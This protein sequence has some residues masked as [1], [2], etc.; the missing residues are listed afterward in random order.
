MPNCM[1]SLLSSGG[2]NPSFSSISRFLLLYPTPSAS[3]YLLAVTAHCCR[4]CN[5]F[6]SPCSKNGYAI[7]RSIFLL[8]HP[9]LLTRS[10]T[11]VVARNVG[12]LALLL[13]SEQ[14]QVVHGFHVEVFAEHN[15]LTRRIPLD[16][17]R[18]QRNGFA[19]NFGWQSRLQFHRRKW[20]EFEWISWLLLGDCRHQRQR[21]LLLFFAVIGSVHEQR[22]T[23]NQKCCFFH[24]LS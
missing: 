24:Y 23:T 21:L 14:R 6:S 9:P 12:V 22:D 17:A 3:A 4:T 19:D 7:T 20:H 5:H 15:H 10:S 2:F 13:R 18:L 1:S 8:W 11:G 16:M